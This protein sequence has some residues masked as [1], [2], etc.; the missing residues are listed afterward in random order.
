MLAVTQPS[1]NA[2]LLSQILIGAENFTMPEDLDP[3]TARLVSELSALILPTLT[4]SLTSA[5][6]SNDFT[7]AVE[8]TNRVAQDLRASVEKAVRSGIDDSRAGR[9]MIMQSMGTILEEI[10]GLRRLLERLPEI[11]ENT[12]KNSQP[13]IKIADV[14]PDDSV[15]ASLMTELEGISERIDT[16]TQGIKAFFETYAEHRENDGAIPEILR[17]SFDPEMFSGL[18]GLVKAESKSHSKELSELSREITAMTEENNTALLHEVREVV[19]E[20]VSGISDD[21][22]HTHS[23]SN[24]GNIKM[25]K[26]IALLSGAGVI[27]LLVE[28][29]VL[30]F[31]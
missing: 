24:S 1:V 11:L 10:A 20:E 6:P 31:K 17:P 23:G 14:K 12:V 30:L 4:K 25:L 21:D 29:L 3:T 2:I 26:I 27:L 15:P 28:L 5:I 16:L 22:H 8:R 19:A 18:E 13:E 9:S 7:G